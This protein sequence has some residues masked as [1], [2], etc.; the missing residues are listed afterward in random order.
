MRIYELT[1]VPTGVNIYEL[2]KLLNLVE[3]NTRFEVQVHLQN[4]ESSVLMLVQK[5][6]FKLVEASVLSLQNLQPLW[7]SS[8][9][10]TIIPMNRTLNNWDYKP[11]IAI[12]VLT[13]VT[14]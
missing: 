1:Q 2:G 3:C 5:C 13:K 6:I 7:V 12:K 14:N 4:S 10:F 11:K 9:S 8:L